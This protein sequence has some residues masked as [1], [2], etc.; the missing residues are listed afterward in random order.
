M[1]IRKQ[2][3][4]RDLM[5]VAF[6]RDSGMGRLVRVDPDRDRHEGSSGFNGWVAAEG[7]SDEM[8]NAS[9]EPRRDCGP[10]RLTL[11]SVANPTG[12][13]QAAGQDQRR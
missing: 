12:E 10:G 2:G 4:S 5:F 1:S 7:T 8:V 11:R 3:E 9:F 6:N 13:Q